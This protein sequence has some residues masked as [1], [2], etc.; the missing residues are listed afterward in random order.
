[1][2]ELDG[3]FASGNDGHWAVVCGGATEKSGGYGRYDVNVFASGEVRVSRCIPDGCLELAQVYGSF[4]HPGYST[5]HLQIIVRKPH[6][7]LSVNGE[8]VSLIADPYD[9][10]QFRFDKG[11]I[12]LGARS[13]NNTPVRVYFDN[14]KIWDISDLALQ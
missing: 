2:L 8:W 11:R 12:E 4:V 14:L 1:V 3:R 9:T 13:A 10:T 5:N 6:I 7:A